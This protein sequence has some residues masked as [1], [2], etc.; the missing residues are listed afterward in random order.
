[1][2]ALAACQVQVHVD[3]AAE[4]DG[5]GIVTVSIGLDEAAL[6]RLDDPEGALRTDDLVLAGWE[7]E[8]PLVDD[9]GVTWW[10][11]SKGFVDAEALDAVLVEVGGAEGPLR[12]F[13]LTES[14]SSS[15]RTYR[16]T[17]TLDVSQGLDPYAD[18]ELAAALGGD[19][20]AGLLATI[21]AQEGRPM[22]EMVDVLLTARLGDEAQILAPTLLDPPLAVDVTEE[23][24]KSSSR[25]LW[26][27]AGAAVVGLVVVLAV[28]ARRRFALR[29]G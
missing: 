20:Y 1:M 29:D 15:T 5:S 23:V 28:A 6:A 21:E 24:P 16:L 26:L 17:G 22:T 14:E 27:V 8:G 10:R 11:A 12:D 2:A 7:V 25:L 13:E 18:P 4:V 19:P 3:V 9:V